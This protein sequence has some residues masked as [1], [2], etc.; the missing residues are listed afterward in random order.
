MGL[1]AEAVAEE[2]KV[3]REMQDE[4]AFHS[5]RKALEALEKGI[6]KDEIAPINVNYVYLDNN[7]ERQEK[8]F[9]ALIDEG[10]RKGTNINALSK[11]RPV[12]K[13]GGQ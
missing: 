7:E 5:H 13:N 10:P 3:T 2:F 6:F 4:F 8:N 9:T 12:F 1:T 11:L